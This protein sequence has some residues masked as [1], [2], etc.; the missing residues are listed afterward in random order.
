M[1]RPKSAGVF[2]LIVC[3]GACGGG[4]GPS[5]SP[6]SPTS[7]TTPVGPAAP[8]T[9][10][11]P[12][13][14][15]WSFRFEGFTD[16]G[17][18]GGYGKNVPLA[19]LEGAFNASGDPVTAVMQP[20]GG[21]FVADGNRVSF[22]GTRSG[23][24]IEMVSQVA[25]GQ[26]VRIIATLSAAGK[27]LEGTYTITGGCGAG[28]AGR[29]AGRR[30]DLAGIWTGTIGAI[31]TVFDMQVASTPDAEG[32]YVLSGTVTFSNTQCFP[33]AVITRRARGRVLFP[34]VVGE[35]QRLEVIAEISEDLSTM[36]INSVLVAG[37][38]P[39]LSFHRGRLVRQ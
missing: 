21:C 17:I 15:N 34:D 28:K 10:I 16:V 32:N 14:D 18:T 13:G 6:T 33:K 19:A 23:A 8:A 5:P 11:V 12:A 20:F 2:A 1:S 4:S 39:E 25:Q 7:P 37:T 30:V 38:C 3:L 35:T 31:P 24:T 27:M 26:V 36:F 22:S 9:P 29:V